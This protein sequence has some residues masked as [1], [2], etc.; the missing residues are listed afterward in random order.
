MSIRVPHC[1]RS[2]AVLVLLLWSPAAF[3][4][5]NDVVIE[6]AQSKVVTGADGVEVLEGADT[7]LPGDIIEY[8]AEYRNKGKE[9]VKGLAASLPIPAGTRF[10][11]VLTPAENYQASLDGRS[12]EKAP[13][14][15]K[16]KQ[17]DGKIK[18]EPVPLNLYRALR[19]P[20]G[21]IKASQSEVVMA[22]VQVIPLDAPTPSSNRPKLE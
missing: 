18:V 15:R 20:L 4:G 11:G 8:R 22:R 12:F 2:L 17:P 1:A 5:P 21:T 10:T 6:L 7:A 16:V 19:W 13:L 9:D 14:V 3:A